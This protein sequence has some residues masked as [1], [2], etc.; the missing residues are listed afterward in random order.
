M[1]IT[2]P[3]TDPGS[4]NTHA[5]MQS[6][7]QSNTQPAHTVS[8]HEE[9]PPGGAWAR[10]TGHSYLPSASAANPGLL[11]EPPE[12]RP[13][14]VAMPRSAGSNGRNAAPSGLSP[15]RRGPTHRLHSLV[16]LE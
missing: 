13:E 8:P 7:T 16:L 9:A 14:L 5:H 11:L 1:D 15:C 10:Q 3:V 2:D 4:L 6:H 12:G